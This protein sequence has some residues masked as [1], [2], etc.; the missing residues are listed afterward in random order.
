VPPAALKLRRAAG[1]G[2]RFVA[3]S[4]DVTAPSAVLSPV[5]KLCQSHTRMSAPEGSGVSSLRREV[6]K[7]SRSYTSRKTI[8]LPVVSAMSRLRAAEAPLSGPVS[9]C[10]RGSKGRPIPMES[11]VEPLSTTTRS[12]GTPCWLSAPLIVEPSVAVALKHGIPIEKKPCGLLCFVRVI[13]KITGNWF[14]PKRRPSPKIGLLNSNLSSIGDLANHGSS[15]AHCPAT[16]HI[17][18]A[19][20]AS[21]D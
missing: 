21:V 6:P 11:S 5:E 14:K 9:I 1:F 3:K 4:T 13:S 12:G 7:T 2:I 8:H 18:P 15:A 16:R 20:N 17:H 10:R 19:V